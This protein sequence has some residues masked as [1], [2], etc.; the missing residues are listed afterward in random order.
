MFPTPA[1]AL[2]IEGSLDRD[3]RN[4]AWRGEFEG[5]PKMGSQVEGLLV[6]LGAGS[7]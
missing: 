6:K 7:C 5:L 4:G 3:L 1:I 2:W